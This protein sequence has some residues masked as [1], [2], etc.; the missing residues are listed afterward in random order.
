MQGNSTIRLMP[1]DSGIWCLQW[2]SLPSR[3][4]VYGSGYA[5]PSRGSG[6]PHA[7]GWLRTD[8]PCRGIPYTQPPLRCPSNNSQDPIVVLLHSR[9]GRDRVFPLVFP[10]CR[11]PLKQRLYTGRAN[12]WRR[13]DDGPALPGHARRRSGSVTHPVRYHPRDPAPKAVD[14]M[15]K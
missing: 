10:K 1:R 4:R 8:Y 2:S 3:P 11:I 15:F 12:I 13:C 14:R 6:A 7:C 5:I 9:R